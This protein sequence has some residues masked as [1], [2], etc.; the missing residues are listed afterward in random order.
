MQNFKTETEKNILIEW[1]RN[2]SYLWMGS[3][4]HKLLELFSKRRF[5]FRFGRLGDRGEI[6]EDRAQF[7]RS[8]C[9]AFADSS[10]LANGKGLDSSS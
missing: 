2:L 6:G 9:M 5:Q 3:D 1:L 4:R 7:H 10:G 8:L